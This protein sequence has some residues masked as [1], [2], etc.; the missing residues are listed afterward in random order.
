MTVRAQQQQSKKDDAPSAV[1][2][3]QQEPQQQPQQH[4]ADGGATS[5]HHL[6]QQK[7]QKPQQKT[8]GHD[9]NTESKARKK[10]GGRH[11]KVSER[12]GMFLANSRARLTC[13]RPRE[14]TRVLLRK[15]A[16]L[17]PLPVE[18]SEATI[19]S[20]KVWAVSSSP[21]RITLL[22]TRLLADGEQRQRDYEQCC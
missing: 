4:L 21:Q 7:Q 2:P 8:D 9:S 6:S 1:S 11:N 15:S 10:R 20:A 17:I 18:Q 12:D 14:V 13:C 22:L 5:P 19:N 3:Q 16:A